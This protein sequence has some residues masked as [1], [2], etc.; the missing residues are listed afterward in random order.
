MDPRL[1]RRAPESVEPGGEVMHPVLHACTLDM[2]A[3]RG[4]FGS[5]VVDLLGS[6]DIFI[7]LVEYGSDVAD[8]GLFAD[9]GLPRLAPSQFG[10][11][12]APAAPPGPQ[13]VAALLQRRRPGVLPVH[14]ASA[15][16]PGG[17]RTVPRAAE[18]VRGF[19]VTDRRTMVRRGG[20]S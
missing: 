10:P 11:A 14:R 18:V 7:A 6:E 16:T 20:M 9:Q 12:P 1:Q 13:R 19:G 15:A 3:N 4:D 17:W 2:P 8:Q 5:G